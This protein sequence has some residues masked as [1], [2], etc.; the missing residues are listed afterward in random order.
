MNKTRHPQDGCAVRTS[1]RGARTRVNVAHVDAD[2]TAHRAGTHG[3][4]PREF[5]SYALEFDSNAKHA[6]SGDARTRIRRQISPREGGKMATK[7]AARDLA[8]LSGHSEADCRDVLAQCD[9]DIDRAVDKLLNSASRRRDDA[10]DDSTRLD[11]SAAQRRRPPS[12]GWRRRR[13][14]RR[15]VMASLS[16]EPSFYDQKK[17]PVLS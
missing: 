1:R 17:N 16:R 11:Y 5:L 7:H 2:A 12:S 6:P 4:S 3:E 13:R 10:T 9:G 15:V 8:Q 14:G